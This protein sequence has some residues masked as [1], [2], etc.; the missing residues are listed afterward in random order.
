MTCATGSARHL[1]E[2]SFSVQQVPA[3]RGRDRRAPRSQA[4]NC[5]TSCARAANGE[6]QSEQIIDPSDGKNPANRYR[7]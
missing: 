5:S 4:V 3:Y 2:T 6:V 1:S 7:P